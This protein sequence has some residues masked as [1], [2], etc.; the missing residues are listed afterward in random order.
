MLFVTMYKTE[1]LHKNTHSPFN[2]LD[3][4]LLIRMFF[5]ADSQVFYLINVLQDS[6]FF[7]LIVRNFF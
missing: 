3:T 1:L 7:F 5:Y 6:N 4:S 2:T